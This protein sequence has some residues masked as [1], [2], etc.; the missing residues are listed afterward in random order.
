MADEKKRILCYG[1]S[2][3]WGYMPGT[4]ERYSPE[5]R[6]TGRVQ[7]ILGSAYT[8]LEEGLNGRTT[9][10][11]DPVNPYRNG[12][13]GLGYALQAVKPLDV[14]VVSLGT[15][16]L[17]FTDIQGAVRGIEQILW[18]LLNANSI[19]RGSTPVFRKEP[20]VLLIA[21]PPLHPMVDTQRTD[22]L[23]C[24][25][26]ADSQQFGTLYRKVAEQFNVPFLNAADFGSVSEIDGVHMT[27]QCHVAMAEAVSAEIQRIFP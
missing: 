20:R 17:H 22:C 9:V 19:Y 6:W 21:P 14:A 24:G 12:L 13:R 23:L 10:Y 18:T 2:N 16:D 15:N 3:T 4:G 25:K 27:V 26:V 5:E 8:V 1:D 7:S 11:E